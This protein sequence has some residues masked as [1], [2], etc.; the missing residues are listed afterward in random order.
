M[1]KKGFIIGGIILLAGVSF[2]VYQNRQVKAQ[3]DQT[4]VESYKV[5][6]QTP[7]HL[8][9]QVQ[10]EET[11]TVMVAADKG[12][13]RKVAVSTGAK[14]KKGQLLLQYNWGEKVY[15]KQDSIVALVN[16][17][18]QN[19]SAKPIVVLKSQAAQIKGTVTEYDKEKLKEQQPITISYVNQDKQVSGKITWVSDLNN[20]DESATGEKAASQIVTYDYTAKADQTIPIGYSVEIAIPRKEIHLPLKS[21]VKK[22]A[23]SYVYLVHKDQVSEKQVNVQK[24]DGFYLLKD[25]IKEGSKIAKDTKGLEDGMDVKI[26]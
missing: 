8:K 9:G 22:G 7:L 19:D 6:K 3:T 25:G 1:K 16:E 13:V 20:S 5:E 12:P 18:A 10:P 24:A 17:D 26:Q 2:F 11:Q 21:V 23:K 15:A 14:V 4:V